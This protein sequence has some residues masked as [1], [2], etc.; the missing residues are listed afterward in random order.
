MLN[1]DPRGYSYDNHTHCRLSLTVRVTIFGRTL[2]GVPYCCFISCRQ[3]KVLLTTCSCV[4]RNSHRDQVQTGRHASL[5][6]LRASSK[7]LNMAG[8]H[9]CN[10]PPLSLAPVLL[11]RAQPLSLFT[12]LCTPALAYHVVYELL[13]LPWA[14]LLAAA[15]TNPLSRL[16][17]FKGQ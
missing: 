5:L 6:D 13:W 12:T 8:A 14:T 4:G 17:C 1:T 3:E 15:C 9:L 2:C 10:P 16:R 11:P 7:Q